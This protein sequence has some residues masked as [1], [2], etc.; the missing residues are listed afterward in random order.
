MPLN[1][2]IIPLKNVLK[3]DTKHFKQPRQPNPSEN[4][5]P[6]QS[7]VLALKTPIESL[8][9]LK[10][11]EKPSLAAAAATT[12]AG[13]QLSKA[14]GAISRS[15]KAFIGDELKSK[16]NSIVDAYL[17]ECS[18]DEHEPSDLKR[19]IESSAKELKTLQL[20]NEQL[21][22]MINLIMV[23]TLP[24]TDLDRLNVSKLFIE[25]HNYGSTNATQNGQASLAIS[26][27]MFMNGF[28]I[29]LQNLSSLESEYHCVK[30]NISL[31]AARAV[32]DQIISFTDL[33]NL[34][35]H[36][37]YYPLF[38][39]CMQNMHKL[40]TPEWLRNQLERSKINLVDM[41][42]VGDR[43]KDRLIQILEDRELS[44]VYP[45]L[46]IESLLYE[47]ICTYSSSAELKEWIEAHVEPDIRGSIGFIQ[48][49]VTW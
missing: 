7:S 11:N 2:P 39:L 34:M 36:G 26:A 15:S 19:V 35:R 14:N 12:G 30:S 49:L 20:S 22:E 46:K 48:S 47:K 16:I 24:R 32:C 44:F 42:S 4:I 18:S 5:Q 9:S 13:A 3:P 31:Y 43:N 17:S 29:I 33:S 21:S 38:F 6:A 27:D 8:S 25:F 40:K 45:M 10:L 1:K 37:A 28:K 23:H 41:L